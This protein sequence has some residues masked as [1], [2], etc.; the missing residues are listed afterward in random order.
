MANPL[1]ALLE[2]HT[3]NKQRSKLMHAERK[4]SKVA[5]A[6]PKKNSPRQRSRRARQQRHQQA[7]ALIRSLTE[8]ISVMQ[9]KLD[10]LKEQQLNAATNKEY[11]A[12]I[13]TAEM[14]RA[15]HGGQANA[16]R[17]HQ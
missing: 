2:L 10:E 6:R 13:N 14:T 4:R 5:S 7:D 1:D 9:K 8:D 12:A 17:Q 16:P 11:L 15:D 3:M